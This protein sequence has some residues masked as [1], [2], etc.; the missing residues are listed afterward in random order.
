[1]CQRL[2]EIFEMISLNTIPTPP[3][4]DP[5]E[6]RIFSNEL[7]LCMNDLDDIQL[8]PT[9]LPTTNETFFYDDRYKNITSFHD[10]CSLID[11][12]IQEWI[13]NDDI[14]TSTDTI[15]TISKENFKLPTSNTSYLPPLRDQNN[16]E[17]PL[18]FQPYDSSSKFQDFKLRNSLSED[19][20]L[21]NAIN[22]SLVSET[23]P[24][25]A[26]YFESL[27][28]FP[29]LINLH[30]PNCESSSVQIIPTQDTF[31][32]NKYKSIRKHRFFSN[33]PSSSNHKKIII[34]KKR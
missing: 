24:I 32:L 33:R 20:K 31:Q 22:K 12:E 16:K 15:A 34:K 8:S 6:I 28:R 14:T 29:E 25:F 10:L 9:S 4:S 21:R 26:N 19:F 30:Y 7:I 1:M 13:I 2:K 3:S 23:E 18:S 5:K 27:A 11:Q 17:L